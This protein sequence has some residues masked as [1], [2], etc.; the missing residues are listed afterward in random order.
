MPGYSGRGA[1][2]N[3][4]WRRRL[5]PYAL[6]LAVGATSGAA[7]AAAPALEGFE[8][9]QIERQIDRTP[10][11]RAPRAKALSDEA[12]GTR[13]ELET[14]TFVL[15]GVLIEGATAYPAAD[16]LPLY[17]ELLGR[18]I[19]MRE[20]RAL[21]EAITR[22]YH[23]N[24]YF[25]S[26][27][28]LPAQDI[29]FGL[30]RIRVIEGYLS[31]WSV[32]GGE[33]DAHIGRALRPALEERPLR[34][35]TLIAG[36]RRINALPGLAVSPDLRPIDEPLGA[37]E[38]GLSLD[39]KPVSAAL[40]IDNRG[41]G[42]V[43]P[44][45]GIATVA[46]NGLAGRHESIRLR[47]ARAADDD[48][49]EYIDVTTVW[50]IGTDG[51]ALTLSTTHVR[52]RPGED[53]AALDARVANDRQRIGL[54]YRPWAGAS[55]ER[56]IGGRF[57]RYRSRTAVLGAPRLEDILRTVTLDYDQSWFG[58][59]AARSLTL[60]ITRGLDIGG[61]GIVDTVRGAG[62]GATN[63]TRSQIEYRERRIL[64]EHWEIGFSMSGQYAGDDLPSSERYSV[65]GGRFGSAYDP[66]EITGD[67]G[68]AGRVEIGR[69]HALAGAGWHV[70]PF[71]AWDIGAVWNI[72]PERVARASIASLS[73]GARAA[74]GPVAATLEIADPLTRPVAAEGEDGA[75]IFW[76][77]G[78]AY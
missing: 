50:P 61:A 54:D 36:L 21:T 3:I 44:V 72:A 16:F 12:A 47:A 65:G 14:R 15:A 2:G 11:P 60:S 46:L 39:L 25:L 68:L 38:L 24:G 10:E 27:A 42:T 45:R 64:R 56:R 75:R 19:G 34:R 8:P 5:A 37:H 30:V 59:A 31:G 49:L 32:E 6:V 28:F 78:L 76:T 20:L 71:V 18:R 43:G 74:L 7:G 13:V 48:E 55:G 1:K 70:S 33:R 4:S 29:A 17:R 66:S 35:A 40:S 63:F 22:R 9:A 58:P 23:D 53:L 52:S 73:A 26:S 41:S 62:T 57:E 51:L 67:H 69:R 77:I